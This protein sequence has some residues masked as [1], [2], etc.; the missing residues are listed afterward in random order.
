MRIKYPSMTADINNVNVFNNI[1]PNKRLSRHDNC[2][3][4]L[5]PCKGSF[6]L[7]GSFKIRNK[8]RCYNY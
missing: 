8:G 2:C 7:K 5:E 3:F 6:V 4:G 1:K